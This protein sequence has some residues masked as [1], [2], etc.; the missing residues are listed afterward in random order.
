MARIRLW[1][2]AVVI[3]GLL[4]ETAPAAAPLAKTVTGTPKL[5]SIEKIRF[6]P[7]GV[8]LI[9]DGRGSQLVAIDTGDTKPVERLKATIEQFDEK[10]AGRLGTTAKGVRIV[11]LAVNPASGLAYIAVLKDNK[12]P[13][14]VTVDGAGKIAE[15]SLENVKYARIALPT[16]EKKPV[17]RINDLAWAGDRVLVAGTAAE[18]FANKILSVPAPLVHE[19][20]G[21][22]YS[23]ETYHVSHR[24]WETRAPMNV[25]LPFE[26]GGKK[27]LVGSF[28]CTPVV[29]YP[30]DDLKPGAHVK[31]ISVIELGSGNQPLHMFTYEKGGKTFVLMNTYRFHHKQRPFGPSPHWTVRIDADLLRENEKVNEKAQHRIDG[32]NQ[33]LTDRMAMIEAYHGVVHMD[34]LDREQALVLRED[35]KGG[36]ILGP[37]A[38]P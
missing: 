24:A 15:F 36:F 33:P 3:L 19:A 20:Q 25:L 4:A 17:T 22:I 8:L 27:Y 9:G 28:S 34:K 2:G 6:A 37:L 1:L 35:G 16:G 13:L 38:L 7:E 14:I 26:D 29:K 32:K 5:A 11:D 12:Q 31:G 10:L 23:T 21:T 18:E 30:L